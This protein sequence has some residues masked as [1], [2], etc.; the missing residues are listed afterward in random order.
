MRASM[1]LS[2]AELPYEE[3]EWAVS[4]HAP[5]RGRL[6]RALG[7]YHVTGVFWYKAYLN[8]VKHL[9][10]WAVGPLV[11]LF[12]LFFLV[13]LRRIRRALTANLAIVLGPCGFVTRLRRA[14]RTLLEF[15]WC[16][17]ERA[18]YFDGRLAPRV[19]VDNETAWESI[20]STAS[21]FIVL[22]AHVGNWEIASS[23]L[24][25]EGKRR[26]H[27]VREREMSRKAQGLIRERVEQRSGAQFVNHFAGDPALSVLLAE[28]LAQ[29]EIVALQGDRPRGGGRTLGARMFGR[30][31]ALPVGPVALARIAGV[32]IVPVFSY[33]TGRWSYGVTVVDPIRVARTADRRR[34][35]DDAAAQVARAI[36]TAISARPHQWFCFSEMWPAD[37]SASSR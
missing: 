12:T 26:V 23:F 30:T 11:H 28:R 22:T 34:D 13:I 36:E 35:L 25:F 6:A 20:K 7:R 2:R 3:H 16:L 15:A 21:G 29:G 14:H 24:P 17:T 9:P 32:P 18:E 10:S 4:A 5:A 33:R 19:E 37:D 27:V 31:T 8:G 1:R